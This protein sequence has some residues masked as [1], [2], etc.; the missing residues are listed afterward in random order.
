[1]TRRNASG[2]VLLTVGLMVVALGVAPSDACAQFGDFYFPNDLFGGP[3]GDFLVPDGFGG[4]YD[5][6]GPSNGGLTWSPWGNDDDEDWTARRC[7]ICIWGTARG[8]IR[9]IPMRTTAAMRTTMMT[10]PGTATPTM[11]AQG[12]T[13]RRCGMRCREDSTSLPVALLPGGKTKRAA[14]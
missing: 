11:T 1:M 12:M 8:M 14:E 3:N 7:S 6:G 10:P 4:G 9:T 2:T 13:G 5:Y